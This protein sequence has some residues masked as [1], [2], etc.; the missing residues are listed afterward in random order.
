MSFGSWEK[1]HPGGKGGEHLTKKQGSC[2][3]LE[4]KTVFQGEGCDQLCQ[5]MLRGQIRKAPNW[6]LDLAS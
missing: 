1:H 4:A 3:D 5:K 2:D 6:F